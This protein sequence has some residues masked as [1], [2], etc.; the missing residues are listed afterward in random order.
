[1]NR[2][3]LKDGMIVLV[4]PGMEVRKPYLCI[5]EIDIVNWTEGP[6]IEW[7]TRIPFKHSAVIHDY[8]I[9]RL[10]PAYGLKAFIF[11]LYCKIFK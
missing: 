10:S 8:W 9:H 6:K 4:Q 1:M 5:V 7:I 2:S 11:K 3:D